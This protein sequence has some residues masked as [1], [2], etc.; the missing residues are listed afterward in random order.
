MDLAQVNLLLLK[1]SYLMILRCLLKHVI[2]PRLPIFLLGH[3]D[4][5]DIWVWDL[6][7]ELI[8]LGH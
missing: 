1:A 5:L 7:H 3:I 6:S 8:V 2:L 4:T